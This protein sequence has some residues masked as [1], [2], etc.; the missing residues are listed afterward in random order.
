MPYYVVYEAE[1]QRRVR[2]D[3]Y[4]QHYVHVGV[5]YSVQALKENGAIRWTQHETVGDASGAWDAHC[6]R[7]KKI[8]HQKAGTEAVCQEKY[9]QVREGCLTLDGE[10]LRTK[11]ERSE[12][13]QRLF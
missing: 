11:V 6:D 2:E 3:G 8:W 9:R 4:V 5:Y 13:P 10:H 1:V 7:M 12:P